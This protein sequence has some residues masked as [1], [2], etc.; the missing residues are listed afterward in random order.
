MKA[1]YPKFGRQPALKQTLAARASLAHK[2]CSEG[3]L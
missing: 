3:G 1:R 2:K